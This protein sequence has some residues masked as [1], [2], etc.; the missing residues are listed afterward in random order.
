MNS[1][2]D[3]LFYEIALDEVYNFIVQKF[4]HLKSSCGLKKDILFRSHFF[5]IQIC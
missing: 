1:D 5:G 2:E 3:K 4:F